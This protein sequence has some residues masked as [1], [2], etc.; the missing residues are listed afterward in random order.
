MF[1]LNDALDTV[2]LDLIYMVYLLFNW[3]APPY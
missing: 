1:K 3:L 2:I